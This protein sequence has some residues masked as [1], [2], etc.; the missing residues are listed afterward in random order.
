MIVRGG[1]EQVARRQSAGNKEGVRSGVHLGRGA[2]PTHS[3]RSKLTAAS[4][5]QRFHRLRGHGALGGRCLQRGRHQLLDI[6]VLQ[7]ARVGVPAWGGRHASAGGCEL[8]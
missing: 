3:L 5:Q 6:H 4:S 8:T 7:N 2:L 1:A